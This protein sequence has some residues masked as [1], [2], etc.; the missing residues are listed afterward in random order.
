MIAVAT[1]MREETTPFRREACAAIPIDL[2]HPTSDLA[3]VARALQL[4]PGEEIEPG[5]A[6][7]WATRSGE[8]VFVAVVRLE[9][10]E[11]DTD[12]VRASVRARVGGRVADV[13]DFLYAS[14]AP[15]RLVPQR[16]DIVLTYEDLLGPYSVMI[17]WDEAKR[18]FVRLPIRFAPAGEV[19]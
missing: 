11:G 1:G 4:Q 2:P 15:A 18:R 3:R 6:L 10:I 19:A 12:F 5:A 8:D 14:D 17:V 13:V 9:I 16:T 7:H